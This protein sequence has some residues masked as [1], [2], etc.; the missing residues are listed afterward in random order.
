MG[1][2]I[3][4]RWHDQWYDTAEGG[5]FEREAAQR[6]NWITID[7]APGPSGE[8]GSRRSPGAITYTFPSPAPGLIA[9]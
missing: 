8:G 3:E 7:G 6:R 4:G 1:L 5:R 2:L 9:P